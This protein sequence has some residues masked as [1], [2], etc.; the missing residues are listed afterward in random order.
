[1][2]LNLYQQVLDGFDDDQATLRGSLQSALDRARDQ[3]LAAC[4]QEIAT[5]ESEQVALRDLMNNYIGTLKEQ[6][7][8]MIEAMEALATDLNDTRQIRLA[9]LREQH[10]AIEGDQPELPIKGP[11]SEADLNPPPGA[12]EADEAPARR[13]R[14]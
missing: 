4:R 5:V 11:S 10:R 1:M 13:K 6:C 14:R 12:S 2:D 8:A 9:R 3:A 7:A